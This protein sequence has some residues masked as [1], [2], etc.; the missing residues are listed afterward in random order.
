MRRTAAIARI[1]ATRD[2]RHSA[3]PHFQ[4]VGGDFADCVGRKA[5]KRAQKNRSGRGLFAGAVEFAVRQMDGSLLV[6]SR[7]EI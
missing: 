7:S 1:P 3:N 6:D 2:M 4:P 5:K